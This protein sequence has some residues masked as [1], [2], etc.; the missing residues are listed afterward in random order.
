MTLLGTTA[1]GRAALALALGAAIVAGC[2]GRRN[3]SP[4]STGT[5][6][7]SIAVIEVGGDTYAFVPNIAGVAKVKLGSGASLA[8]PSTGDYRFA[9]PPPDVCAPDWNANRVVC[10]AY[11]SDTLHV[12]DAGAMAIWSYPTGLDT[13]AAI[14]AGSCVVCALLYDPADDRMILATAG[15][16]ALFDHNG[17]HALGKTIAALP[18]E[19]FGYD[20][21]RNRVFSPRYGNGAGPSLDL[22]DVARGKVYALDAP[23]PLAEPDHGAVDVQTDIA[24][25]TEE[26][27]AV[28]Y[29]VD[30][31]SASVDAPAA[32]SFQAPQAAVWLSS[33]TPGRL[34]GVAVEPGSH[35]AF[36]AADVGV[37][38]AVA[39]LPTSRGDPLAVGDYVVTV[40]PATPSGSPWYGAG[41][42]HGIAVFTLPG[43]AKPY[44]LLM[45]D[46]R[47]WLAVV[48]MEALLQAP[49]SPT[50]PNG[51]AAG[52]DLVATGVVTFY[53]IPP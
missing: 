51:V 50:D 36:L 52:H 30:L 49:R 34:S 15:G 20:P 22:V 4:S 42:P 38:M 7:G 25:A 13:A 6:A 27:G 11:R 40:V 46:S 45:N 19:N 2:G 41:D 10:G 37:T 43:S 21:T 12:V 33:S 44:G 26:A 39:R 29:L 1:S 14:S 5:A 3:T 32:G 16:Y 9:D 31:S 28:V 23:P 18:S 24:I 17:S 47:R 53:A 48:D 8:A 35:L